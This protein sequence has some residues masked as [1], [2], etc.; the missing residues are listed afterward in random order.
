MPELVLARRNIA[1]RQ[2]IEIRGQP[3]A[4]AQDLAIDTRRG[5]GGIIA[6][7][8]GSRAD[9]YPLDC[10][11]W[12]TS[13]NT[14]NFELSL[15]YSLQ[16]TLVNWRDEHGHLYVNQLVRKVTRMRMRQMVKTTRPSLSVELRTRWVMQYPFSDRRTFL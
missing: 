7:W 1:N 10:V 9:A 13:V 16:G 5:V 2:F 4:A 11:S 6:S 8:T 14:A 15:M 3:Q 12:H